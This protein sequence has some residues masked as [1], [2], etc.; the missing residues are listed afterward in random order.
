MR[1]GLCMRPNLRF[2]MRESTL[3]EQRRNQQ[4]VSL[5]QIIKSFFLLLIVFIATFQLSAQTTGD[6]HF[7]VSGDS[8]NCGDVVMPAIAQGVKSD[9]AAF[10]WHLGDLRAIYGPDEDYKAEPE[11][12]GQ[13]PDKN[14]YLS[15]AWPDFIQNQLSAFAP[16]PFF[17]GIGNHETTPPKTR[18]EFVTQF[19]QWLDAPP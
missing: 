4:E 16:V 3:D 6:W 1:G 17:V 10:Y 2:L 19:A 13:A 9:G 12:R 7:A 11:H 14:A 8:R 5:V 15:S 18:A